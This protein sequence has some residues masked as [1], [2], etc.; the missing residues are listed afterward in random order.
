VAGGTAVAQGIGLVSLPF[1]TRLYP[2]DLYGTFVLLLA[3]GGILAPVVCGRFEVAIPL[4]RRYAGAGALAY[5]ALTVA[6][7]GSLVCVAVVG[8]LWVAGLVEPVLGFVPIFVLLAGA[9]QVFGTWCTRQLAYQRLS[10]SRVAQA[11]VTAVLSIGLGRAL[12]ADPAWLIFATVAGQLAALAV[13]LTGMPG[14]HWIAQAKLRQAWRL[15][16]QQRRVVM[17]N[18]PHVLADTAQTSGLPLAIAA[19]F[20]TQ[21]AAYF[22]FS[23]RLLKAPLGLVANAISQ[24]FYPRAAAHRNDDGRL[25]DDARRL[26]LRLV[27]CALLVWLLLV[28][29]PDGVYGWAFG[30]AWQDIGSYVRALAPWAAASFVIGPL[31]VLYVVKQRFALDLT[32]G[33]AGTAVAFST[34]AAFY[35]SGWSSLAAVWALSVA[36]ALYVLLSAIFEFAVVIVWGPSRGR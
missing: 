14:W 2:P 4:P 32:L 7:S 35:L 1:V 33:L 11:A 23:L 20:G 22:S 3:Y 10:M 31:A 18:V 12:G 6:V 26:M 5:G 8:A 16:R 27:P 9:M 15:L 13:L 21:A 24:V 19:L 17:F 30:Q 28:L 34:L 36:M 25:R 29:L